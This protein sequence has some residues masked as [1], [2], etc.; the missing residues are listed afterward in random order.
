MVSSG[1]HVPIG[2]REL[3]RRERES[4]SNY[5]CELLIRKC[6]KNLHLSHVTSW[7]KLVYIRMVIR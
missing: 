2:G 4:F 5:P 7:S 6:R 3:D 1:N